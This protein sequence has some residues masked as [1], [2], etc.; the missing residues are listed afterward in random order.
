[1][2]EAAANRLIE[3][4][5][6][7]PGTCYGKKGFPYIQNKVRSFNQTS[8]KTNYLVLVDFM[9]TGLACPAEVVAQWLPHRRPSL[10][11]RV[12]V[13][14]LESWLLADRENLASFLRV[15]AAKIPSDPEQLPDPKLTLVNIARFSRSKGIRE[16]LVP[17]AG[18]T[19]RIGKL[20]TSEMSRFIEADWDITNA[21]KSSESLNK[22]CI[23]LEGIANSDG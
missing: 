5:G 17:E 13:R 15:S 4:A 11:F 7:T 18:S 6:H 19:A 21:R 23:H 14:E 3:A 8:I 12:V 20:Y 16:A 10:L 9:D 22:C 1:M 2:D